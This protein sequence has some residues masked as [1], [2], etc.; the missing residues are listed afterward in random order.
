LIA[1]AA[2]LCR[3]LSQCLWLGIGLAL[4]VVASANTRALAEPVF[5]PVAAE[6]LEA[7]GPLQRIAED[8]QGFIWLAGTQ[9]LARFDGAK[10]TEFFVEPGVPGSL[11]HQ[12]V[13]DLLL[14]A[15]GTLWLATS[16]GL[17]RF[18]PRSR[19]FDLFPHPI[20]SPQ[21]LSVN[22]VRCL[23]QD[24]QGRFWLG[25]RAGLYQFEPATGKFSRQSLE[26]LLPAG[27]EAIPRALLE[28]QHQHLWIATAQAG[29]LQLDLN[30]PG[31]PPNLWRHEPNNPQSLSSNALVALQADP[32]GRL[33]VAAADG[34]VNR[35]DEART[36]VQRYP[37]FPGTAVTALAAS[38][39]GELWAASAAGLAR[40][41]AGAANWDTPSLSSLRSTAVSTLMFDRRGELWLGF[42]QAGADRLNPWARV[43]ESIPLA[44]QGTP[45]PELMS[46]AAHQ[47]QGTWL[48]LRPGLGF[49]GDAQGAVAQGPALPEPLASAG[50]SAVLHTQ[51]E[52]WL[53]VTGR[54]LARLAENGTPVAEYAPVRGDASSL[55]GR[56]VKVL[57]RDR[58]QALWVGTDEGLNRFDDKTQ[59]FSRFLPSLLQMDG[60]NQLLIHC[61]L[62][63]SRGQ[64]W[65]GAKRGLYRLDRKS[66]LFERF[67]PQG[68]ASGYLNQ[69]QVSALVESRDGT[70]WAATEGQGLLQF[71]AQGAQIAAFTRQEGMPDNRVRALVEDEQG[72]LWL[73]TPKG[74]S[75]FDPSLRHFWHFDTQ[76]GVKAWDLLPGG[77]FKGQAG[78]V[79]F[80]GKRHLIRVDTN[81]LPAAS[82]RLPVVIDQVF[83]DGQ[84]LRDFAGD[85]R[86]RIQQ[87]QTL[88]LTFVAPSYQAPQQVRYSYRL[89]GMDSA[90]QL[91]KGQ[92]SVVYAQLPPGRYSFQVR[93]ALASGSWSEPAAEQRLEV[94]PPFWKSYWAWGLYA[95]LLILAVVPILL[96]LLRRQARESQAHWRQQLTELERM[97]DDFLA[98]TSHEL[99]TPLNG[100]MGLSQ[101]LLDGAAGPHN[102]MTQKY[103][104]M[105]AMS[106]KR[107]A[108]LVNDILDFAKLKN[109]SLELHKKSI[110][111]H[112]FVAAMLKLVAPMVGDKDVQLY[113]RVDAYVSPV[114]ADEDRLQQIFY[115][116]LMNAIKFT[117]QGSISISVAQLPNAVQINISDTGIGIPAEQTEKIFNA[118]EQA[119]TSAHR[120]YG[121]TGL[122]LAVTKRLVE[123][124]GGE[125]GVQSR[126]GQGSTFY[127][128]LPVAA[129]TYSLQETA[130]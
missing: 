4:V 102:E 63:D 49:L 40:W 76:H 77:A 124:H 18:D 86:L 37:L 24:S 33:W 128:S 25:T 6:S 94:V 70:L 113:N 2:W 45:P 112:G 30:H 27:P 106:G 20:D 123:L 60:E 119:D 21:A 14:S 98:N 118:F 10:L 61:L 68:Q 103:L 80:L 67:Y 104:Q 17:Q 109:H 11:V 110:E 87:G 129:D 34:T 43:F 93:A 62:E 97:K 50:I 26:P 84:V 90:W 46:F 114:W 73:S 59:K 54:G 55:L 89:V 53:G 71:D 101:S 36:Q 96:F 28:D 23:L 5:Q 99:R 121:G 85:G 15:D 64:F 22:D 126:V 39:T 74:L 42:L 79:Y 47:Q 1:I 3:R 32:Q 56:D 100:I 8:A 95:L 66:G 88:T 83:L 130:S 115:N 122:G 78:Q 29:L 107:L 72:F 52:L 13:N 16:G 117:D 51:A 91:A 44:P 75:R 92:N 116:L 65:V 125:L 108:N 69:T 9:G 57:Y 35:I 120:K 12:Q 19:R 82:S 41:A 31:Q 105:I 38:P 48:G 58:S 111:L 81:A 127:F 7:L